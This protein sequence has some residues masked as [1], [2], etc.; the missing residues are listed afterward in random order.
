MTFTQETDHVIRL[1][2]CSSQHDTNT[3]PLSSTAL[4]P[5]C[6]SNSIRKRDK[7]SLQ[8]STFASETLFPTRQ[9]TSDR[10]KDIGYSSKMLSRQAKVWKTSRWSTPQH[11]L[12]CH[13]GPRWESAQRACWQTVSLWSWVKREREIAESSSG[14]GEGG[15][16][17]GVE[18]RCTARVLRFFFF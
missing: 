8:H 17:V 11:Y 16:W 14:P 7:T 1:Q 13:T 3:F 5:S 2:S 15:A 4:L 9:D 6:V 12:L 10:H 18:G